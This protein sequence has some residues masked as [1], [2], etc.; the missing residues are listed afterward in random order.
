M[1]NTKFNSINTDM[2]CQMPHVTTRL[3]F[4]KKSI[5]SGQ[6]KGSFTQNYGRWKESKGILGILSQIL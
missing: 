1:L 2:Y 3:F 4:P 5:C 6:L